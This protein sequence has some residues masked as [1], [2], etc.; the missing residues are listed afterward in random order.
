MRRFVVLLGI[1][2]TIAVC[3]AAPASALTSPYAQ[4]TSG[5]SN[6]SSLH[7]PH[8]DYQ[9][10]TVKCAVCH[11]VH[12][13]GWYATAVDASSTSPAVPA[14]DSQML[15]RGSVQNACQYCHIDSAVGGT[16]IYSGLASNYTSAS[17]YAHDAAGGASCVGCHAVHG[18]NTING[19]NSAKILKVRPFQSELVSDLAGGNAGKIV[20]ATVGLD[21]WPGGWAGDSVQITAFC[22]ECH[23]YYSDASER[24]VSAT[25]YM[26]SLGT[27]DV[28]FFSNHPLKGVGGEGANPAG[29]GFVAQGSSLVVTQTVAWAATRGCG[30]TC[31]GAGLTDAGPG[32]VTS[33]FPHYT[34]DHARFLVNGAGTPVTDPSADGVCINC[35]QSPGSGNATQGVGKTF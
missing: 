4:W 31:H 2:L 35:H 14:Q 22:T 10:T 12:G 25:A 16:V 32:L 8:K 34:P 19:L 17:V 9:V 7:T 5:A 21:P 27:T 13:A 15:L 29:V 18:A 30:Q 1:C 28:T 26:A 23:P 33:S 11:A 6:A 24:V 20:E 3:I